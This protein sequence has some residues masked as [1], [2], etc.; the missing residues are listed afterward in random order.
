MVTL[1]LAQPG[2]EAAALAMIQQGRERLAAQGIDQWQDGYPNLESI[3]GDIRQQKGYFLLEDGERAGYFCLDFGGE[4]AYQALEGHW[5]SAGPYGAIHRVVIG[6]RHLG[7]GLAKQAFALAEA[8]CRRRGVP[9]LRVDTHRDN[10]TM[11]G[12]VERLGFTPCGLV[13]YRVSGERIAYEKLLEPAALQFQ[14]LQ[15]GHAQGLLP[16][17]S[18]G[19]ALRFTNMAPLSTVEEARQRI[20]VLLPS[21]S[22]ALVREGEVLGVAGCLPVPGQ[23]GAYGLYYQLKRAAWGHGD[24]TAAA[25]WVLGHM[26]RTY[27]GPLTFLAE[28]AAENP[29]SERILQSCGF[30]MT[31]ERPATHRGCAI[32]LRSYQL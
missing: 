23:P 12:L 3:Q 18:D 4:P 8:A 11:R 17:W 13:Y 24:G 15:E 22:F 14:P 2:Q 28:V 19:E 27:D 31:G 1:E 9:S 5:L 7:R 10:K 21:D 30:R 32:R 16:L 29:A 6:D 26:R 25:R 20:R